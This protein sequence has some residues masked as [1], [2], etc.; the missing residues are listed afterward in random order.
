MK[1]SHSS[2]SIGGNLSQISLG[3]VR[4]RISS[5]VFAART[6]FI[7]ALGGCDQEMAG[8]KRYAIAQNSY[9]IGSR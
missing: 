4:E 1:A 2:V 5:A 6:G 3:S 8:L 9:A 7:E